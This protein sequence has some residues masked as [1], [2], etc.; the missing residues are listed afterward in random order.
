MLVFFGVV[1]NICMI[2]LA[3]G[4]T[5]DNMIDRDI[6]V[7]MFYRSEIATIENMTII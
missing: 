7:D 4:D 5:A 6:E 3:T 2:S 1:F